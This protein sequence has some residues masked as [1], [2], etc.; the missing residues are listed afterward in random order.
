MI[1]AVLVAVVL[2]MPPEAPG[3]DMYAL[4]NY[5]SY[6]K[7]VADAKIANDATLPQYHRTFYCERIDK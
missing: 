6:D 7:C 3:Q 4:K 2:R 1:E 5:E